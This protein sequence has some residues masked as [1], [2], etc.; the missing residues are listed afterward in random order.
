MNLQQ[1]QE[2]NQLLDKIDKTIEDYRSLNDV[3]VFEDKET[4]NGLM[5]NLSS[6]LYFLEGYLDEEREAFYNTYFHNVEK[7]DYSST[8][9]EKRAKHQHPFKR[10]IERKIIAANKVFESMRSNQSFLKK[11]N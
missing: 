6:D 1:I 5:K 2:I 10:K 7:K 9:S 4:I 8:E 3:L 11:D